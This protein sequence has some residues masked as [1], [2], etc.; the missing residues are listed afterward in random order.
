MGGGFHNE[1]SVGSC[2]ALRGRNEVLVTLMDPINAFSNG[3][4]KFNT[5]NGSTSGNAE[6]ANNDEFGK[7]NSL[8]DLEVAGDEVHLQ[9][10]N[11]V[12]KD[13]DGDGI[14]DP[15][16]IGINNV[17]WI[18]S[19]I[20]IMTGH[21]MEPRLAQPKLPQMAI[22]FLIKVMWPMEIP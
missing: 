5:Q 10:G 2:A 18:F 3:T 9:I 1:T 11:R 4:G 6:L 22:T 21:P 7:G 14:Q 15:G 12:W 19:P 20:L 17:E 13:D 8:G 16:E